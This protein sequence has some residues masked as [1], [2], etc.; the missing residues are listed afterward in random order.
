MDMHEYKSPIENRPSE[1]IADESRD[2]IVADLPP[3]QP[4]SAMVHSSGQ[5]EG[6]G[7]GQEQR[8]GLSSPK[9]SSPLG[10]SQRFPRPPTAAT[11]APS[12]V[13]TAGAGNTGKGG[14]ECDGGGWRSK[15]PGSSRSNLSPS[16][17]TRD[18][19]DLSRPST[20]SARNESRIASGGN[21]GNELEPSLRVRSL[22]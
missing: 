16:D 10:L 13:Q 9:K 8:Q 21:E 11:A 22:S 14:R 12:L 20:K 4:K 7:Q 18:L 5:T 17:I 19:T 2:R 15:A 3:A 1:G 6:N